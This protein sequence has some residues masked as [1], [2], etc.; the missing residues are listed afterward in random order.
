MLPHRQLRAHLPV[1]QVPQEAA[2]VE[3]TGGHTGI[4]ETS[5]RG[6]GLLVESQVAQ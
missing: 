1:A 2:A 5:E 4:K 3:A 6:D